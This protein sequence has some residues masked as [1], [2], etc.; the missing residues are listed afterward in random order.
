MFLRNF[1]VG[2][3]GCYSY[4][5]L[6]NLLDILVG[7]LDCTVHL[8]PIRRGIMMFDLEFLTQGLHHVIVQIGTVVSDNFAGHTISTDDIVLNE[9]DYHLLSHVGI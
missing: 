6:Y 3:T 1:Y 5:L 9:F 8:R 4:H 2:K 7:G